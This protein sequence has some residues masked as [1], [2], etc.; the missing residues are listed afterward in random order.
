MIWEADGRHPRPTNL[1]YRESLHARY[2]GPYT[3]GRELGWDGLVGNHAG[4]IRNDPDLGFDLTMPAGQATAAGYTT[5]DFASAPHGVDYQPHYADWERDPTA[6]PNLV[7]PGRTLVFRNVRL[8]AL[9]LGEELLGT[10]GCIVQDWV[11]L[12]FPTMEEHGSDEQR[13][14]GGGFLWLPPRSGF[15]R[16]AR[17]LGRVG[18]R[19]RPFTKPLDGVAPLLVLFSRL[20]GFLC[21]GL[22]WLSPDEPHE[23]AIRWTA[24]AQSFELW[25]DH[26]RVMDV[27]QGR[28]ALP[29]GFQTWGR[30]EFH[31]SGLHACCWQDNNDGST[32]VHGTPGNPDHDQAFTI[33]RV[34]IIQN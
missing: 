34:Q 25:A 4:L 22:I 32:E 27:R 9:A 15:G 14:T 7:M 20:K 10:G 12:D 1:T 23:F 21:A 11:G 29:T 13:Y 2:R 19:R 33:E 5:R 3:K 8:G 26:E 18:R 30:I 17:V 24:D 28:F 16:A 31:R 6:H